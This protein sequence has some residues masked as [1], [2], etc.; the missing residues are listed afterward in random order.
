MQII[1]SVQKEAFVDVM[2]QLP[3]QDVDA[4]PENVITEKMFK[5][6]PELRKLHSLSPFVV[7]GLL[8]VGG[9]LQNASLPFETKHPLLLPNNHSVTDLQLRYHH[10]KKRSYG[11][12]PSSGRCEQVVLDLNGRSAAK[13][14]LNLCIT[15]RLWKISQG[16]QQMRNLPAQRVEAAR[17]FN[18]VGTD[19]MGPILVT[20]GRSRV[21]R[22]VC[23]FN[24]LAT[25]AVHLE[26]VPSQDADAFIQAYRRFCGRRNVTPAEIFSDNGGNFVAAEKELSKTVKWH[27]NPPRASHHGGFYEAFFRI[28]RQIF[29]SVVTDSTLTEFDL[30]TYMAE[31]ERIINNR[32]ITKLP[33]SP[34][35]SAALTPSAILTGSLADNSSSCEFLKAETYRQ[36]WKKTQYL[37]TRFW[38]QKTTQYLHLLQPKQ[39]W[40]GAARNFE[41]GDLVLM[42]NDKMPRGQWPKAVVTEVTP[43]KAGLLRKVRARTADGTFLN[44]IVRKLCLLEGCI[45]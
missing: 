21:K 10:E 16:R 9:R 41:V 25:R 18:F 29:R 31:I 44:Q 1:R 26:V 19:L 33:S 6:Q 8:R 15:C 11:C 2:K 30:M 27:F 7:S 32:P 23:I 22:Y 28:F 37:A 20:I 40:F 12:E 13:R 45:D 39:K 36:A 5:N 38:N 4:A 43:Y 24:C 14:V 17:P 42:L 3:C 34:N 35:E